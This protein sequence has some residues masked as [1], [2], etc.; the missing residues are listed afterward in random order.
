MEE[1]YSAL[2]QRRSVRQYTPD[3]VDKSTI[4]RILKA[5]M[6]APSAKNSKPWEFIVVQNK[7]TLEDLSKVGQHWRMLSGAAAAIVVLANTQ[8]YNSSTVEFFA[9]D[10]AACTQNMLIAAQGEGLGAVWLGLHPKAELQKEVSELLK[11][12]QE[13][14][15]FS[16]ISLGVPQSH[17][18]PHTTYAH[19]K[20]HFETY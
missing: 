14:I 3:A 11:I 12:P 10:C 5:G 13:I 15:P 19:E 4:E 2:L 17:P 20:V 18:H 7:K 8:N 9:Q 16:I 6:F 1:N